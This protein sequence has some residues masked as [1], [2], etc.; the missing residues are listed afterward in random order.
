MLNSTIRAMGIVVGLGVCVHAASAGAARPR[1]LPPVILSTAVDSA[2]QAMVIS[3]RNFGS[4]QPTVRLAHRVLWVR[5]ASENRV[6]VVLPTGIEPATYSLT[7]T[8]NGSHR[9]TTE[10]FSTAVFAVA[11]R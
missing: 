4:A 2:Q 1:P 3:G 9:L 5:S 11:D 6:V 10:P 8:T 7:V